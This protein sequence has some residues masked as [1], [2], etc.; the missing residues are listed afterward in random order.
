MA[1]LVT[2]ICC[3]VGYQSTYA[4]SSVDL[5]GLTISPLRTELEISPGTSLD[6]ALTVTNSTDKPMMVNLTAEEFSVIDQQ[7]DYAF[8][9]ESNTAKWVNFNPAQADLAVGE[10]K[11]VQYSVGVPLSAEPGGRYISLFASNDISMQTDS[12][13]RQRVASL[14]YITV[15]GDVTRA[16]H[17]ISFSSPW[18]IGGDSNWSTALQNTG[19]T[20]YR[21]RYSVKVM[22]ILGSGVVATNQGSA[23]I[24]PGTVR[25]VSDKLP[26]PQIPGIYKAVYFI[27]LGDTPAIS[28]TRY[29][30]YMP[31]LAILLSIVI[32]TIL[33]YRI[34]KR[35]QRRKN[36]KT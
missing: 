33:I 21:S 2:G 30:I 35:H 15:S 25:L 17:L 4:V 27:G 24:L 12:I 14:L 23:L 7:Y 34:V 36:K 6:G 26:S 11:K 29:F 18:A 19:T 9:A 28:E 10:T 5:K 8:T 31:P 20:H 3:L 22:N 13:A 1:M 16:G 32:V